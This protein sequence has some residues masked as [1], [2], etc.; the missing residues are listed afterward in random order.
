[1]LREYLSDER[2]TAQWGARLLAALRAP[3]SIHVKGDLGTGKTS[4]VRAVLRASGHT[5]PVPSPTY[6][7]LETYEGGPFCVHH[8]DLY[9]L[10]DPE[11]LEMIGTR[12]YFA[13]DSVRFIEWPERGRGFLPDP[14][15]EIVLNVEGL[16]RRLEVEAHTA[17]GREVLKDMVDGAQ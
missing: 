15:L 16:G 8:F 2:A 3:L 13:E 7:L 4:L 14:D 12:D 11:E 17:S 6:T 10:A 5:G 9:R 1:M